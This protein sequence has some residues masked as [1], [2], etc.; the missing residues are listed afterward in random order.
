MT[1]HTQTRAGKTTIVALVEN[2]PGV[3]NRVA[4][5]FRRRA[6]NVD[7][8]TVGRTHKEHISRMTI[9]VDSATISPYKIKSNLEKLVNVIDVQVLN[10]DIPHVSRDLVLVKVR[11]DGAERSNGVTSICERYPAKIIDIGPDVAI[12][13]MSGTE[14][15]VEK[16]V[17]ELRPFEIVEMVRTGLVSMGRGTRI[18]DTD[19]QPVKVKTVTTQK[20]TV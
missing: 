10:D 8:L 1:P 2:K 7:S 12:I 17:N 3:L 20:T 13:E 19:Y 5:L 18:Q 16:F 9:V 11:A 14:D 4:S 15:F 6:F